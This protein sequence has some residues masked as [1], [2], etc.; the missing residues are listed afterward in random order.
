MRCDVNGAGSGTGWRCG[1]HLRGAVGN[2][3]SVLS[4]NAYD[5]IR[6][7]ILAGQCNGGSACVY[8]AAGRHRGSVR[9]PGPV[10]VTGCIISRIQP[11]RFPRP[12][13]KFVSSDSSTSVLIPCIGIVVREAIV[14]APLGIVSAILPAC[15]RP[16]LAAC[17]LMEAV[18]VAAV[19]AAPI[20][21][22]PPLVTV[23]RR[24]GFEVMPAGIPP[25]VICTSPEN[26][27]SA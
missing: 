25:N 6:T 4:A 8:A 21:S 5:R 27:C 14:A 22:A 9:G 20:T 26:P 19:A 11:P 18:P 15:D 7:E 23:N 16:L 24:C 12:K 1:L 2:D 13:T 3:R 10:L 17:T